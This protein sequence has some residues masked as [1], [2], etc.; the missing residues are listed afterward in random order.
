MAFHASPR[1]FWRR[2]FL[3]F[4]PA[5][6]VSSLPAQTYVG[7]LNGT[8]L[9]STFEQGVFGSFYAPSF[10]NWTVVSGTPEGFTY[11]NSIMTGGSASGFAA[12]DLRY[13]T[14]TAIAANTAYTLSVDIGYAAGAINTGNATYRFDLGTWN[15]STFTSLQNQQGT[16][17]DV[18]NI[19]ASG[20]NATTFFFTY[21]TGASPGTDVLAVEIQ[22]VGTN[23]GIPDFMSFDNVKL[24]YAAVP[25]PATFA[26]LAG[27]GVLGMAVWC[28]RGRKLLPV[29]AR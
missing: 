8:A 19:D 23:P 16:A 26:T 12:Y 22:Q 11:T 21:T 25:E 3:A 4:F 1:P 5:L 9:D 17:P 2:C 15:G 6:L 14:S 10:Y 27:L 28:R 18:G 13:L 29:T 7:N 20:T 24:S